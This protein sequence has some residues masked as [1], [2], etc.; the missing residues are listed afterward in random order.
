M[1]QHIRTVHD[2]RKD[3]TCDH[4]AKQF[5]E[6]CNLKT[7]IK[8]VHGTNENSW[9]KRNIKKVCLTENSTLSNFKKIKEEQRNEMSEKIQIKEEVERIII[10]NENILCCENDF[11]L[12]QIPIHEMKLPP[13]VLNLTTLSSSV[14]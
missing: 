9:A 6:V 10:E 12:D 3:Y 11:D 4:C 1:R 2:G 5:S 8:S 14:T 13:C 7:H